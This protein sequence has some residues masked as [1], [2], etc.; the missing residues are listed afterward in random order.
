MLGWLILEP[1]FKGLSQTCTPTVTT[2]NIK[3]T[4]TITSFLRILNIPAHLLCTIDCIVERERKRIYSYYVVRITLPI[5]PTCVENRNNRQGIFLPLARS[6]IHWEGEFRAAPVSLWSVLQARILATTCHPLDDFRQEP[7][8]KAG[9]YFYLLTEMIPCNFYSNRSKNSIFFEMSTVCTRFFL[10]RGA[11]LVF[12]VQWDSSYDQLGSSVTNWFYLLVNNPLGK[13]AARS[14]SRPNFSKIDLEKFNLADIMARRSCLLIANIRPGNKKKRDSFVPTRTVT[15]G[16]EVEEK[17]VESGWSRNGSI[18][19]ISPA[20]LTSLSTYS[21]P[22]ELLG[23]CGW[24][25]DRLG[26]IWW[27]FASRLKYCWRPLFLHGLTR[28]GKL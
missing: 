9:L 12:R 19:P 21:A 22:E 28:P 16:E 4:K 14:Q 11:L 6:G 17:G 3:C 10:V 25:Q 24:S 7:W 18:T 26:G 27:H 8:M 15:D 5:Y 13:R 23:S 1:F 2:K 20:S